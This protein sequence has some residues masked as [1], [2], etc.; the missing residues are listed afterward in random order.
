[1]ILSLNNYLTCSPVPALLRSF[2]RQKPKKPRE[3]PT[4]FHSRKVNVVHPRHLLRS[5][6]TFPRQSTAKKHSEWERQR[7]TAT[8]EP[9]SRNQTEKVAQLRAEQQY[10]KEGVENSEG[11]PISIKHPEDHGGTLKRKRQRDE[12]PDT[13][14]EEE[15]VSLGG[16]GGGSGAEEQSETIT[17]T[18]AIGARSSKRLRGENP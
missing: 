6:S 12:V 18:T 11:C 4:R 5:L 16:K 9:C 10:A 1:M 15:V 13:D 7:Q 17:T 3:I 2:R 14:T 8:E